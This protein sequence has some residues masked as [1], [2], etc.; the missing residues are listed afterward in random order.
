MVIFVTADSAIVACRV[1]IRLDAYNKGNGERV[2]NNPSLNRNSTSPSVNPRNPSSSPG[3]V[4]FLPLPSPKTTKPGIR[5]TTATTDLFGYVL[6]QKQ[7]EK[8]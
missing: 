6:S 1:F 4:S 5:A 2:H 8:I 3:P 7:I